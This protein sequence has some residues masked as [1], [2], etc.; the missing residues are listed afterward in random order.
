M[1]PP[2]KITEEKPSEALLPFVKRYL[3]FEYDNPEKFINHIAPTGTMF[4]NHTYGD[5]TSLVMMGDTVTTRQPQLVILGQVIRKDFR[6]EYR[7]IVRQ[8]LVE[9]TSTGFYELFHCPAHKFNNQIIDIREINTKEINYNEFVEEIIEQSDPK[10]K[11]DCYESL[12]LRL[13]SNPAAIDPHI[14]EAVNHFLQDPT[15]SS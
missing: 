10:A 9:F 6:V 2:F 11:K 15:K 5:R 7:G 8:L 13:A 4:L 1:E 12:L 3:N 14:K